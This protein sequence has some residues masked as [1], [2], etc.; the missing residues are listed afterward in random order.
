[1]KSEL[2]DRD[3]WNATQKQRKM[4]KASGC[5]QGAGE[6]SAILLAVRGDSDPRLY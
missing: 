6:L 2:H 5:G 4:A 1:M 3:E